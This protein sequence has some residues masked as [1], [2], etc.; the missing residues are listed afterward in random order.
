MPGY[1]VPKSRKG[2]LPWQHVVE[3][4]E[5][6]QNYWVATVDPDGQ[7]HA[8]P[9]W[10]LWVDGALCFGGGQTRW[11]R[12][13][14]A[15][16]KVAVHLESASEVVILE[17]EVE[18]IADPDHPLSARAD[19]V[20]RAKYRMPSHAPFYALRPRVAFAWSASLHDATRWT[21]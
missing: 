8:V 17:G 3:R 15:N 6:T 18:Y 12:N 11:M 13:L 16:P 5:K 19:K 7:P 1:G 21:F 10:A 14:A 4:M 20:S 9:V 2:M